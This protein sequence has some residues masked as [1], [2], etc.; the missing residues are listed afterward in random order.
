MRIKRTF[1]PTMRE[2]LLLVKREQGADAVIL[3]NKK[4][5]GGVEILS[6]ID[7]DEA[8][9]A[10]LASEASMPRAPAAATADA[11]SDA[12]A[13]SLL[14]DGRREPTLGPVSAT[15]RVT[16]P[17]R[18]EY[19]PPSIAPLAALSAAR[20][21]ARSTPPAV[22]PTPPPPPPRASPPRRKNRRSRSPAKRRASRA[23]RPRQGRPS[24]KSR[25]SCKTCAT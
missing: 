6:A 24:T 14:G 13:G 21:K 15:R 3:G 9:L 23:R 12:W 4:V 20:K 25:S 5:P 7:F 17:P 16:P 1:A 19:D 8:A 2:A 22:A 11:A 18:I 10:G